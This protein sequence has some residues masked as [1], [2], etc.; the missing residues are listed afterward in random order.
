ME[1]VCSVPVLD[2]AVDGEQLVEGLLKEVGKGLKF[3]S[4]RNQV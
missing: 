4:T 2:E 1:S 3:S